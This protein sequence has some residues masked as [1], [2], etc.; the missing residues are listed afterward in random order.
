MF[1]SLVFL[2]VIAACGVWADDYEVRYPIDI[3]ITTN[4]LSGVSFI[5]VT[6]KY[7]LD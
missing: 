7:L 6:C 4:L 2:V 1:S 5:A 3:I